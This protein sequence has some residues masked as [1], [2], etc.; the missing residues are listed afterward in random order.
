MIWKGKLVVRVMILMGLR[1]RNHRGSV[2]RK[3]RR[4]SSSTT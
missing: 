3:K 1:V 4:R 2:D